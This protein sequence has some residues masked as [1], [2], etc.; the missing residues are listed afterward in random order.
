MTTLESIAD[1]LDKRFSPPA[2]AEALG[3]TEKPSSKLSK[4]R[5]ATRRAIEDFA[6][7]KRLGIDVSDLQ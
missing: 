7:A 6:E 5:L 4:R 3:D 1:K 2:L